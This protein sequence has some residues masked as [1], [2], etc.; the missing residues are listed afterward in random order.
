MTQAAT[1]AAALARGVPGHVRVPG[2]L[3]ATPMIVAFVLCLLFK[4]PG[5]M[6]DW[7]VSGAALADGHYD[8]LLLHL[9]A[10]GGILHIAMN[11]VALLAISPPL[12]ARLGT[13][14]AAWLR[15]LAL[16]VASGLAGALAYLAVNPHGTMP[17]LGASG[18]IY[19]LLG[20]LLR[21]G[22]LDGTLVPLRSR[23]MAVVLKDFVTDNILLIVL[24]SVPALLA[25]TG[26][27]L[28]WE[29]HVG[30]FAFGLLVGPA[31]FP[32]APVAVAVDDKSA[33]NT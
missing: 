15:Y 13:P 3:L 29:A 6:N 11:M 21:L 12:V 24:F 17:M 28:A 20:A 19:G 1:P 2:Y 14:P 22:P 16:F 8:R 26:G 27:G 31:F 18:A 9:F 23:A 33:G 25:G 32:A 4:G 7:G 30:G 10:H 5:G